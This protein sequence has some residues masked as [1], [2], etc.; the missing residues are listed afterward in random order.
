MDGWNTIV[1]FWGRAYFQGQAASF[2]ECNS[3]QGNIKLVVRVW[4]CM[5]NMNG[6]WMCLVWFGLYSIK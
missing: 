6:G 5:S 3:W 1:S 4:Q 2:R